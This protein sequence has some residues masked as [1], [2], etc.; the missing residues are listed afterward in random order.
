MK[1][2]KRCSK[3]IR[4]FLLLLVVVLLLLLF[5]IFISIVGSGFGFSGTTTAGVAGIVEDGAVAFVLLNNE[6]IPL[7]L[8]F[9]AAATDLSADAGC[10][11][12]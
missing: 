1:Y 10:V 8:G 4:G 7:S 6:N 5:L 3:G 9:A 2:F 12:G 11:G